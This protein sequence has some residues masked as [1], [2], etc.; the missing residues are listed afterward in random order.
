MQPDDT[1]ARDSIFTLGGTPCGAGFAGRDDSGDRPIHRDAARYAA[2]RAT[3]CEPRDYSIPGKQLEDIDQA[4]HELVGE[5]A[6]TNQ[7][8]HE[9]GLDVITDPAARRRLIGECGDVFFCASWCMDAWGPNVFRHRTAP[10]PNAI[11]HHEDEEVLRE[12]ARFLTANLGT[13]DQD[14]RDEFF[15]NFQT[16]GLYMSIQAGLLSNAFKKAMWQR[17][18]QDKFEQAQ[19]ALATLG[20][21]TRI[22][23]LAD[24]TVEDAL[25]ANVTK[26][27]ARYPDGYRGPGGGNRTGKGA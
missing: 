12:A 25:E 18:A 2:W 8:I 21:C 15:A 7:L 13:M 5:V 17:R 4:T 6:E 1:N 22:L 24:A 11:F 19:R 16:L 14:R 20:F 26:L 3:K 9:S 27:D 23:A 10:N